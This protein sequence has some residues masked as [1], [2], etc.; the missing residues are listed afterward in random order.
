MEHTLYS[1][2]LH[3]NLVRALNQNPK[4]ILLTDYKG[5]SVTRGDALLYID[6]IAGD[7]S[8][9][10]IQEGERVIFLVNTS[11]ESILYFYALIRV[12]AV[13]ILADPEMG[14]E[15]FKERIRFSNA[16]WMLQDPILEKIDRFSFIKPILRLCNIW[17]PDNL[18]IEKQNKITIKS[19]SEIQKIKTV[20]YKE[21]ALSQQKDAA[22]IFT[23]GT[24]GTPKGV[25][26]THNSLFEGIKLISAHVPIQENDSLYAS[27]IY[28]LLI[29]INIPCH[30]FIPKPSKFNSEL[31]LETLEKQ[32]IT[33]AFLLPY[34]GQK[35]INSCKKRSKKIPSSLETL[36][37]G[38]APVT[39]TFLSKLKNVCKDHTQIYGI[40]GATEMLIISLISMAEKMRIESN[41]DPLGKALPGIE[42]ILSSENEILTSGPQMYDRYLGDEK[43]RFFYSGDLGEIQED[44]NIIML[45]RK[46][47]MIIKHGY[48]VYPSLFENT[49][50]SIPGVQ[51][52]AM[53]GVYNPTIE[54]EEIVLYVVKTTDS[55]ITSARI[56]SYLQNGKYSIDHQALPD[57]IIFID[58]LP[59]SGRSKKV[60][61]QLL[62]DS[63][64]HYE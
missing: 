1:S 49:I 20:Q 64:Q 40:Y 2:A 7:L 55:K 19:I 24:T 37:F 44:G 42:A 28:F 59:Y 38:S 25:V 15:N 34:E 6:T 22:I 17:F 26:H 56:M 46:K 21:I 51:Q 23:S 8:Q 53:V 27:Q 12:G 5:R 43:A 3:T 4:K 10:G 36:F 11:I 54:D 50:A 52:C 9:K 47:D 61:K 16:Q 14:Q 57:K 60:S 29:A 62:R 33:T 18:P 58:E 32:K 35:I 63:T 13:I 30:V 41:G 39:K 45:G 48:N 31:F